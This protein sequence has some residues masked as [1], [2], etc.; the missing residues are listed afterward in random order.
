MA[1]I[2]TNRASHIRVNPNLHVG[3]RKTPYLT[4]SEQADL[5]KAITA[6][7]RAVD[8]TDKQSL[9]INVS[10]AYNITRKTY[11]LKR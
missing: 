6:L 9:L 7:Q 8:A 5:R 11:S 10:T 1:T 4:T 3:K 2:S